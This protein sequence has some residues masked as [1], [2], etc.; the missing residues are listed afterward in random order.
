MKCTG[1]RSRGLAAVLMLAML[2]LA[3]PAQAQP[4][5]EAACAAWYPEDSGAINV[6]SYGARG[7][8][9][10]D[11]TAS[12]LAA[13]AASGGDTGRAI[14]HDRIVFLPAGTYLVSDTLLK[15]YANGNFASGMIL[16]GESPGSTIL[17]LVDRAPGFGD[18]AAPRAVVMTS[19]KRIDKSGGRDYAGRGEG[20]DAYENFVENLTVDVGSGNP[21]AIGIDYLANNIGAIRDVIVRAPAGSGATGIAMLRKWPGPALLQRVAVQGFDIGIDVGNT[22]YS[23]T[24]S[25]IHLNGQRVAGLR[26]A[27]NMVTAEDLNIEG[28]A[29]VS[30]LNTTAKGMLMLAGGTIGLPKSDAAVLENR[31]TIVFDGTRLPPSAALPARLSASGPADGWLEGPTWHSEVPAWSMQHPQ[32]PHVNAGPRDKWAGVTGSDDNAPPSDSTAVLQAAFASAATVYLRHGTF[33]ISAPLEIPATMH[34]LIGMNSTLRV[35]PQYRGGFPRDRGMLRVL[36]PGQPLAIEHLALDNTDQGNQS[37][38]EVSAARTVLVRDVLGAGVVTLDRRAGG[39]PAFLE[40]SCCGTVRVAGAA[41]VVARQL[42]TEGSGTR[43]HN[44]GAP[45]VILGL[46]TEGYCTVAS[47]EAGASTAILGGLLYVVR[48]PGPDLV[49]AFITVNA[50]LTARFVEESLRPA[51]RYTVYLADR[52]E[53]I[54]RQVAADGMPKRDFGRIVPLL[55]AGEPPRGN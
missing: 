27:D 8:G 24:L 16:V 34:R 21:G 26:N 9:R 48:T 45:L 52:R 49:P 40:N 28:A 22:E 37:G 41:P 32:A 2:S 4:C 5:L 6:R 1:G 38:I 53:S 29:G 18:P 43:I 20:N 7:D 35:L 10:T 44:M 36:Q 47:S 19:S 15:R 33:W 54:A 46:K 55:W 11:D 14:W 30:L 42:N 3:R 13:I 17:R 50:S 25:R 39:G 51:S 12:L 23:V 31:G